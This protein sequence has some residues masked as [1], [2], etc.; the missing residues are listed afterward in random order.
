[1]LRKICF[2][3]IATVQDGMA[4]NEMLPLYK[5]LV[6][7]KSLFVD[8]VAYYDT[9]TFETVK[10]ELPQ[11][12]LKYQNGFKSGGIKIFLD[13]SPQGKTAWMKKP[14]NGDDNCFG[15]STMSDDEVLYAMEAAAKNNV[16]IIAHCNGDAAC[17]QF[18]NCLEKA[19][20]NILFLK[21]SAPL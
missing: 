6:A 3:R 10:K 18:L 5:S 19:E 16:Q 11:T 2:V 9:H 21:T 15:T 20:K 12:V 1:M 4:V 8:L 7:N 14:Y 17:Q 13:G